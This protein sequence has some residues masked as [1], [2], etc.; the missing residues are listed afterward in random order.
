MEYEFF[1]ALAGVLIMFAA[2]IMLP[3][4]NT[5]WFMIIIVICIIMYIPGTLF[6][7]EKVN[8]NIPEATME[9]VRELKN[10]DIQN[11]QNKLSYLN[12]DGKEAV[13]YVDEI[14]YDSDE[15][16]IEKQTL[17][18]LFLYKKQ[19]VLHMKGNE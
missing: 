5:K 3:F 15:T 18:W 6:V 1:I 14:K 8:N 12:T 19:N 17:R 4:I 2:C 10:I 16:Y 11:R 7:C 9:S 13:I